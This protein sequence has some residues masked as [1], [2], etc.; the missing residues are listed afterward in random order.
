MFF[1][2]FTIIIYLIFIISLIRKDKKIFFIVPLALFLESFFRDLYLDY[3]K[4]VM[5]FFNIN[6][7]PIE[8]SS[9]IIKFT[10]LTSSSLFFI[11]AITI[12]VDI[13]LKIKAK[14]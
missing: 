3:L 6:K 8:L 13:F 12:L 10:Y 14:K 4:K 11:F 5:L 7:I 2:F 9:S 1:L